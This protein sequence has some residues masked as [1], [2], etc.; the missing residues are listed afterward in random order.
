M[1]APPW[2]CADAEAAGGAG[3]GGAQGQGQGQRRQ[4]NRPTGPVVA[5][6]T[7]TGAYDFDAANAMLDR[8]ALAEEFSSKVTTEDA[9]AAPE[10]EDCYNQ[11]S[12]F[13]DDI[14]CESKG[15]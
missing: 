13:F 2:L 4:S 15:G 5:A 1:C 7:F 14:S 8:D 11:K 12:S 3:G 6:P 10:A 9:P